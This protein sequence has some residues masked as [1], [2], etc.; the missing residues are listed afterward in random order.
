V[1][2][3]A[4]TQKIDFI[5]MDIDEAMRLFLAQFRLPGESD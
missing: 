3:K 1:V 5:G 2:L 4:F